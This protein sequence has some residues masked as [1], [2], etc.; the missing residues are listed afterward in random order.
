MIRPFCHG[1]EIRNSKCPYILIFT[2][3][4][5]VQMV[6][7]CFTPILTCVGFLRIYSSLVRWPKS[8]FYKDWIVCTLRTPAYIHTYILDK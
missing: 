1:D 2:V 7:M 5:F 3:E 4:R 8:S 6:M